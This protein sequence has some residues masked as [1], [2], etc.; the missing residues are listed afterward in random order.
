MFI[1]LFLFTLVILARGENH[2]MY[3]GID[4][5][6]TDWR[7]FLSVTPENEELPKYDISH[8]VQQLHLQQCAFVEIGEG[9]CA[10]FVELRSIPSTAKYGDSTRVGEFFLGLCTCATL[11]SWILCSSELTMQR[12]SDCIFTEA[13]AYANTS[14]RVHRRL[15]DV[16]LLSNSAPACNCSVPMAGQQLYK[17][18]GFPTCF[19]NP[20]LESLCFPRGVCG[21]AECS[22]VTIKGIL[23]PRCNP[24][25]H[26]RQP[27]CEEVGPW[28]SIAPTITSLWSHWSI[29]KCNSTCGQGFMIATAVCHDQVTGKPAIDCIGPG[30]FCCPTNI[31]RCNC[32]VAVSEGIMTATR[33]MEP[34]TCTDGCVIERPQKRLFNRGERESIPDPGWNDDSD[35]IYEEFNHNN[36]EE[37]YV[38]YP[39]YIN[40]VQ[41]RLLTHNYYIDK[42][43]Y[44]QN[45]FEYVNELRNKRE[46]KPVDDDVDDDTEE[47]DDDE[48]EDY[49]DLIASLFRRTSLAHRRNV[50]RYERDTHEIQ[51]EKARRQESNVDNDTGCED[52]VTDESHYIE[53]DP[54]ADSAGDIEQD[55]EE[56]Y[57]LSSSN[58]TRII[59]TVLL[60]KLLVALWIFFSYN[61]TLNI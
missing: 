15:C 29:P 60:N 56:E 7:V 50:T 58:R 61:C 13:T 35:T 52:D 41:R 34:C 46:E 47:Y 19:R 26:K 4:V 12:K 51:W 44:K 42:N 57:D 49:E 40:S 2:Y 3:Q 21:V 14:A 11:R 17:T 5:S 10:L 31:K 37:E 48:N 59:N 20:L 1:I 28:T 55:Q 25:C 6:G 53:Y 8:W 43:E 23:S 18:E 9:F 16:T 54:E 36:F 32:E 33:I 39:E 24:N 27:F 30:S 45:F 38:N 22:A